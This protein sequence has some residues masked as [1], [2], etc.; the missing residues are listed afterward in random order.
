MNEDAQNMIYLL[1]FL[2]MRNREIFIVNSGDTVDETCS[3]IMVAWEI[4]KHQKACPHV[5][6]RVLVQ[7]RR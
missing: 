5:C 3:I 7:V 2:I 1:K 4:W 6:L